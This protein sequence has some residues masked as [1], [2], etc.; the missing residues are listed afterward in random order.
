MH[1]LLDQALRHA[2]VV[3]DPVEDLILG[4]KA[5]RVVDE[6]PEQLESLVAD[7]NRLI[8]VPQAFISQVEPVSRRHHR[9]CPR[10]TELC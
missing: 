10:A 8:A 7:R 3:P 5:V 2:N 6:Q 4:Q 1:V 9:G